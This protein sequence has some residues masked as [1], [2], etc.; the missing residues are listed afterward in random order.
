MLKLSLD[1]QCE[2]YVWDGET[3]DGEWI[4]GMG[5]N[6]TLDGKIKYNSSTASELNNV[7]VKIT[8][9]DKSGLQFHEEIPIQ[10][11]SSGTS[12]FKRDL[13]FENSFD[14]PDQRYS[15][16]FYSLKGVVVPH[17]GDF[18]DSINTPSYS[19]LTPT[20]NYTQDAI[21]NAVFTAVW[22]TAESTTNVAPLPTTKP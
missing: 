19:G 16:S 9:Y 20:P 2:E 6:I 15:V 18:E 1:I 11:Y 17:S 13:D 3:E 5:T 14:C 4:S 7:V 22:Q 12:T 10:L 8:V 21:L